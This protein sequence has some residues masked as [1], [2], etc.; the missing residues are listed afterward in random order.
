[1]RYDGCQYK[2]FYINK[3]SKLINYIYIWYKDLKKKNK[4]ELI[5]Y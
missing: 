2:T 1:M 4:K 3:V 5:I